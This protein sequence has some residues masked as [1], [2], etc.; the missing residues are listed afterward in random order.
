MRVLKRIERFLNRC[1]LQNEYLRLFGPPILAVLIS[2]TR[3][4]STFLDSLRLTDQKHLKRL[5]FKFNTE[6]QEGIHR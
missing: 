2:Q 6:F 5:N 4:L 1:K 3:L